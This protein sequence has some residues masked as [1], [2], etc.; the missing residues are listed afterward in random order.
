[1]QRQTGSHTRETV[2]EEEDEA[3]WH[4]S[5]A[6]NEAAVTA[7]EFALMRSVEAFGRWQ[8]ACLSAVGE[9]G[10]TGPENALLHL[11][12][13]NDRPKSVRDLARLTNREDVPNIQ[14]S[15]RKL[16]RR[17]LVVREGSPRAGVSYAVTPAGRAMT[18]DFAALRARLLVDALAGR[19]GLDGRLEEA[20]QVLNAMASLYAEAAQAALLEELQRPADPARQGQGNDDEG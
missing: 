18:D 14:Y 15:L 13:M 2:P 10:A 4:L 7:L 3:R 5:R 12:R 17:G 8:S 20:T 16:V 6:P 19:P 1:M 11:I 9:A